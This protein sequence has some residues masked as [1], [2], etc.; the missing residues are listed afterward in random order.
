M[1][2][3]GLVTKYVRQLVEPVVKISRVDERASSLRHG[4]SW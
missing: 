3:R 4:T 1:Q 2:Y